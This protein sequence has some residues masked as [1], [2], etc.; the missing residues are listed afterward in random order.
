M[1]DGTSEGVTVSGG[2][3]YST[4]TASVTKQNST[5]YGIKIGADTCQIKCT[6]TD[7]IK[8]GDIIYVTAFISGASE[9]KSAVVTIAFDGGTAEILN[10]IDTS[11]GQEY[12]FADCKSGYHFSSDD[13]MSTEYHSYESETTATYF[14][15]ARCKG[16]S[17]VTT[18]DSDGNTTST[19][20]SSG[21]TLYINKIEVVRETSSTAITSTTSDSEVLSTEYY[22]LSGAKVTEPVKGITIVKEQLSDGSVRTSK[23]VK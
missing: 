22:T 10:G 17:I 8:A 16:V 20:S 9:T 12:S 23:I 2:S 6:P 13:G 14:D 1:T 18:T 3:F 19:T 4:P 7:G 5:F 11:D 15:L 21:T